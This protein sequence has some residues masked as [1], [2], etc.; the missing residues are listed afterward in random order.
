MQHLD[1]KGS[2]PPS[3][4]WQGNRATHRPTSCAPPAP[5]CVEPIYGGNN[6]WQNSFWYSRWKLLKQ[7]KSWFHIL[8]NT[9]HPFYALF[10]SL[11]AANN[12]QLAW[13]QLQKLQQQS[14][15]YKEKNCKAEV[16]KTYLNSEFAIIT[17]NNPKKLEKP[18]ITKWR[19]PSI[20]LWKWLH[21]HRP[22]RSLTQVKPQ[23]LAL[24]ASHPARS[25]VQ[26]QTTPRFPI[27]LSKVSGHIF[28][29]NMYIIYIY[30]ICIVPFFRNLPIWHEFQGRTRNALA[31]HPH[32]THKTGRG[33]NSQNDCVGQSL[34]KKRQKTRRTIGRPMTL[35]LYS[36]K[37]LKAFHA[38]K[39]WHC[40]AS[41]GE[42]LA[43]QLHVLLLICGRFNSNQKEQA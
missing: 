30:G 19:Y 29:Y 2:P 12:S 3:L 14:P 26:M 31:V 15:G 23:P 16:E 42:H 10:P 34:T 28:I 21:C 40:I 35:A 7:W 43:Q 13:E 18:C 4:K 5:T 9:C 22:F 11:Q 32:V 20:E 17:W 38:H 1:A 25:K 27:C 24:A 33:R 39:P 36:I 37:T 8:E 6:C 41:E